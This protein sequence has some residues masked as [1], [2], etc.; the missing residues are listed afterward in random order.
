MPA[1]YVDTEAA[2]LIAAAVAMFEAALKARVKRADP[3]EIISNSLILQSHKLESFRAQLHAAEP[4]P[5]GQ[6]PEPLRAK[7]LRAA[8]QLVAAESREA[9][10]V[11]WE[12]IRGLTIAADVRRKGL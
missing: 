4:P 2:E 5:F 3:G 8:K 10:D 1:V 11:A 6:L 12:T 9:S 7:A